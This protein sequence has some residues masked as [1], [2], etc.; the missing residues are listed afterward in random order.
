MEINDQVEIIG[1]GP[2]GLAAAITLAKSGRKVVVHEA[3]KEVGNR[4]QGDFQGLENWSHQTDVLEFLKSKGLSTRFNHVPCLQGKAYDAFGNEYLIKSSVPLFY[5]VERGPGDKTLDT[6]LL[7]QALDLGVQVHF[8]SKVNALKGPGVLACGPKVGD[9]IATGYH[10][11]TNSPDGFWLICDDN[12]APKG[13]SYLLVMNGRGTVKSCMFADFK[14][15]RR[16]VKDTVETFK[17]YTGFQMVD[18]EP[19]GGMGNFAYPRTA[20]TGFHPMVGEHAGFQDALFGFGM[21]YAMTS[22]ILAANSILNKKDFNREW[23]EALGKSIKASIVNRVLYDRAG[24]KGY[25]RLF[26]NLANNKDARQLLHNHYQYNFFRRLLYI[27]AKR[28]FS[29]RRKEYGCHEPGCDCLWC[30]CQ[31][32]NTDLRLKPIKKEEE[33]ELNN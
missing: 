2:S 29:S 12:L 22:G 13:Y 21:R 26:Q 7:H 4:F 25:Q 5:M 16:Y 17:K 27:W 6:R 33:Y 15:W 32:E 14:N 30:E 18:P 3:R 10:F 11:K 9:A 31:H 24:N 19:H 28:K 20:Y 23:K 8:E 1:A